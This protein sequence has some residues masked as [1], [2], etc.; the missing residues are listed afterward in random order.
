MFLQGVTSL[1]AREVAQQWFGNLVTCDWFNYLWLNQGLSN[2]TAQIAMDNIAPQ[3]QIW[4]QF[5]CNI[6]IPALDADS[7][8]FSPPIETPVNNL[9]EYTDLNDFISCK[10]GACLIRMLLNYVGSNDFRKGI[11]EYLD[12]YQHLHLTSLDFFAVMEQISGRPVVA[13]FNTWMRT[14]GYPLIR[15]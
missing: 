11:V 9:A 2:Y 3:Y 8:P 14:P 4:S 1:L 7:N 15:G 10:K 13:V 6:C 5:V 12:R